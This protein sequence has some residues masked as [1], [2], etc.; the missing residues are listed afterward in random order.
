MGEAMKPISPVVSGLEPYEIHFGVEQPE[1]EPLPA[2]R[3]KGPHYDVMSRWQP[4][5]EER[6]LIA[7]GADIYVTQRTFG[8]SYQATVVVVALDEANA[9]AKDKI[10]QAFGLDDELNERLSRI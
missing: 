7:A 3:T 6:K 9:A 10:M 4:T 8:N 5:D 2:L 1:Y